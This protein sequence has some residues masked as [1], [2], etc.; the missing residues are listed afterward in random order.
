M[1]KE[2]I[3]KNKRTTHQKHPQRDRPTPKGQREDRGTHF[4]EGAEVGQ[5]GYDMVLQCQGRD[6]GRRQ[7]TEKKKGERVETGGGGGGRRGRR[8]R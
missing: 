4:P 5:K 8:R 3:K 6:N 7:Q 2:P 1:R